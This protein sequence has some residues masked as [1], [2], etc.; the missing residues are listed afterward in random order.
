MSTSTSAHSDGPI[1]VGVGR[2][3]AHCVTP[4]HPG[5][6]RP[7]HNRVMIRPH[8]VLAG[9]GV[10]AADVL[11]ASCDRGPA[12]EV[13]RLGT[14]SPTPS[15]SPSRDYSAFIASVDALAAEALQ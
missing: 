8:R 15:P 7:R 5:S 13:G 9:I 1:I 4:W 2:A 14:P 6:R 12:A 11:T 10:L 3:S